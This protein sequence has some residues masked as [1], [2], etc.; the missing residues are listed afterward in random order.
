MDNLTHSLIGV[1]LSRVG[2]NRLTPQATG[3][4]VLAANLPDFDAVSLLGGEALYLDV[5]R[6]ITHG[7][8]M[9]PVLA[10]LPV[11]IWRYGLR[12][13]VPWLGGWLLCLI[14]VLSHLGLDFVTAYGT[15]LAAPVSGAWYQWP[16]LF[17]VDGVLLMVLLLAL[18]GPALSK[19]VSGEIGGQASSGR[20]WA[21]MAL[22]FAVLWI[23]G[24][25]MAKGRAERLLESRVQN[26]VAPRRVLALPTALSPLMWRGLVETDDFFAAH[27]MNLLFDFDPERGQVLAKPEP[28][29]IRAARRSPVLARFL[30]FAQWPVW[31]VVPMDEPPGAQRVQVFDLRFSSDGS[32]FRTD[33]EIDAS[34]RILKE[35]FH[36]RP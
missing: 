11:L 28:D 8:V 31:R 34:G 1:A 10:L 18:A 7:V 16:V 3:M 2:L 32:M 12:K 6:G 23:G 19:L 5:H 9:S 33:V 26:G 30:T 21:V 13:P 25:G 22:L 24:R 14:G 35:I 15:H 36:T 20:G 4:M 29:V 27:D 17:I